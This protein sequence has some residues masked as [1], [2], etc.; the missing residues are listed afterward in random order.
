MDNKKI[1]KIIC[2]VLGLI[3]IAVV[4]FLVLKQ[5]KITITYI[6]D[7]KVNSTIKVKKGEKLTLPET[8]KDG[9]V[10]EGWYYEGTKLYDGVWFDHDVVLI[11]KW[12]EE[13]KPTMTLTFDTDGGEKLESQTI[14]CDTPLNLPTPKKEGYKFLQWNDTNEIP[15]TNET[16]LVCEDITLKAKWEKEET[17]TTETKKE[18]KKEE[19]K[20]TE[21]KKEYTC[22]SGY[23]LEGTKCK[24][25][26][27]PTYSCPSGTTPDGDL[28]IRTSDNNGG[29]RK[30]KSDTV[31]YDGKGHTWTGEGDYYYVGNSTSSYGKCAYYKW[32]NYTTKNACDAAYD[33]YHKTIWVSELN[34]CYA[35][36]KM[37][38]YETVC[39]GNYKYYSSTE[40]SSKFGI[41]D[42]GKCLRKV[43]KVNSKTLDSIAKEI[44]K[45]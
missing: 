3:L 6:S 7:D 11:A 12:L 19:T 18:E 26:K 2:L 45:K 1:P 32:E 37:G 41:H 28:C 8:S 17:K 38:N 5:N 23:T 34:G 25:T 24:M 42:N 10:F 20:P 35:E 33:V 21:T 4:V 15:I 39:T 44:A 16:K 36:T 43:D 22:P 30:C 29:T 31:A 14:E 13:S 9:Y 27:D 40:L